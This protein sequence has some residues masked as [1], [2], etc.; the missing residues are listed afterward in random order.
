[1][2]GT[3]E[4]RA[5]EPMLTMRVR[6]DGRVIGHEL[7]VQPGTP[8]TMEVAIDDKA[9]REIYGIL[10]SQMDVTD[11]AAQDEIIMLNGYVCIQDKIYIYAKHY[12]QFLLLRVSLHISE[13]KVFRKNVHCREKN[14]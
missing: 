9:S 10:M 2:D 6:Q 11:N 8:L 14:V 3:K 7:L 12:L 4:G 13:D 1:M 5:P